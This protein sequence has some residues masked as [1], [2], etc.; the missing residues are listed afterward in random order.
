VPPRRGHRDDAGIARTQPPSQRAERVHRGGEAQRA[1]ALRDESE[2]PRGIGA[3]T[4]RH[5][6][7]RVH[8]SETVRD[9]QAR[10]QPVDGEGVEARAREI[11]PHLGVRRRRRESAA[12]R[13]ERSR[14]MRARH[15]RRERACI[16]R[17]GDRDEIVSRARAAK[18]HRA[19]QIDRA[20]A[21]RRAERRREPQVARR[22]L[23]AHAARDRA[24]Q[25]RRWCE[26]VHR[27]QRERREP[28]IGH[29]PLA[30]RVPLSAA[31]HTRAGTAIVEHQVAAAAPPA[32]ARP[33]HRRGAREHAAQGH[34]DPRSR[35]CG[36][37]QRAQLHLEPL[38]ARIGAEGDT[39]VCHDPVQPRDRVVEA[40]VG[41]EPQRVGRPVD[42]HLSL[43]DAAPLQV[44]RR[45]E[46]LDDVR[47]ELRHREIGP[48]DEDARRL[49]LRVDSRYPRRF[50]PP[51]LRDSAR[52]RRPARASSC[53]R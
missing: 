44:D 53:R 30:G 39:A 25:S 51:S 50:R 48:V 38:R 18:R 49:A 42:P 10:A 52:S 19:A 24:A 35:E 15:A 27:R 5:H 21:T 40:D 36:E 6:G 2:R 22:A 1:L 20:A 17:V 28:R 14:E 23:G 47:A 7:Q 46:L 9:G 45:H 11:R 13:R 8:P 16:E 43:E 32:R 37:A 31:D 3:H 29:D 41:V 33:V 34:A 12:A 4:A 26:L